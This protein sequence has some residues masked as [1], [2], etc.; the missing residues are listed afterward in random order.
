MKTMTTSL[1]KMLL[2]A[3]CAAGMI[4]LA[5]PASGATVTYNYTTGGLDGSAWTLMKYTPTTATVT[6]E[7]AF[8]YGNGGTLFGL[9][10]SSTGTDY[11]SSGYRGALGW[12]APANQVVTKVEIHYWTNLDVSQ[13][14]PV[15]YELARG[16]TLA[17]NTDVKETLPN[18]TGT[19]PV[20]TYAVADNI[21]GLGL[22]FD[23]IGNS[24]YKGWYMYYNDII[25]TTTIIPEPMTAGLLLLGG[26]CLASVRRRCGDHG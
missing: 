3:M 16:E 17:A 6:W 23:T 26:A 22:G 2:G 10:R 12:T 13:W 5:A 8:T 25:I 9:S 1:Q 7:N 20:F 21:Q 18:S 24:A 15:M 14:A 11:V 4:G 19:S